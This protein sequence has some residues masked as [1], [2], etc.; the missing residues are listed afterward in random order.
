MVQDRDYLNTV[1][2]VPDRHALQ[3]IVET[4]TAT[5]LWGV[6]PTAP[7]HLGYDSLILAQRELIQ[8]GLSHIVLLADYHAVLTHGYSGLQAS[9]R[10][11]Y[12]ESYLR[13]CCGIDA[14]FLRGSRFQTTPQYVEMLYSAMSALP[15][16]AVKNSL[17]KISKGS[18]VNA[19]MVS[20][21]IYGLMQCLDCYFVNA[22][23]IFAERGQAK[24]YRLLD[25]FPP[26]AL[27]SATFSALK[28]ISATLAIPTVFVYASTGT[29]IKGMPLNISRAET[30]ISIH[31][32]KDSLSA[33]IDQMFAA[34]GGTPLPSGRVNAILEFFRCSVFPWRKSPVTVR[35]VSGAERDYASYADFR[36]DYD[37]GAL[38]PRDCKA[39]LKELLWDR[40]SNVQRTM[41]SCI[42]DWVDLDKATGI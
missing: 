1:E 21:Y 7:L 36:A 10:A 17:S 24:I 33:K 34:P 28:R 18:G 11:T 27:S 32:R 3:R 14:T 31:E 22:N 16:S 37:T 20:S 35:N 13:H 38:D 39:A 15:V 25:A 40:L 19:A 42:C 30:R 29:D 2:V 23:V 4:G 26:T 41:G 5:S 9:S 8:L 6:A 12:Y